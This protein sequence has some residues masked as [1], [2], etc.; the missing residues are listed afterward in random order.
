MFTLCSIEPPED[1][2]DAALDTASGAPLPPLP[3]MSMELPLLLRLTKLL[4]E[5]EKECLFPDPRRRSDAEKLNKKNTKR[6]VS[7]CTE[8]KMSALFSF[9]PYYVVIKNPIKTS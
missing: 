4:A 2:T 7:A 8:K 1:E 6:N 9:V 5:L 3:D